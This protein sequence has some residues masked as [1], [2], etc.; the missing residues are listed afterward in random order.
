ML[1]HAF[2]IRVPRFDCDS[3]QWKN[4]TR[5]VAE[6]PNAIGDFARLFN[7][8]YTNGGGDAARR[9]GRLALQLRSLLAAPGFENPNSGVKKDPADRF[10][11]Q[12]REFRQVFYRDWPQP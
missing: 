9:E 12:M 7:L 8:E 6:F 4:P 3:P 5:P 2:R 1:I 11:I 10:G